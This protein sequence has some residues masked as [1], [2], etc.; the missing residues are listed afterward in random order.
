MFLNYINGDENNNTVYGG[1]DPDVI[2]GL[3]GDDLLD[4]AA[5]DDR[6]Y[7]G[8]GNDTLLGGAER[9]LLSG[10]AGNDDL[11]GGADGDYMIG[12]DGDDSLQ[13]G[14]G[15]DTLIG[16][17]GT[18]TLRGGD[19]DDTL[20]GGGNDD[21]LLGGPGKTTYVFARNDGRDI[22]VHDPSTF[23]ARQDVVKFDAG[24]GMSDLWI[25]RIERGVMDDLRILVHT[26]RPQ[27]IILQGFMSADADGA[28]SLD[29]QEIR[30]ADGAVVD[31][32]AIIARLL[33]PS[34]WADTLSGGMGADVIDAKA[35][36]D[37]VAGGAGDDTISGGRGNDQLRGGA[38]SDVYL[39]AVGDGRDTLADV[40]E[41]GSVHG[42]IIRF[43]L[44]VAPEDVRVVRSGT[45]LEITYGAGDVI[46]L[47]DGAAFKRIDYQLGGYHML[48][49]D[50][51]HAPVLQT[52]LADQRAG[53]GRVFTLEVPANTFHDRDPGTVLA[54]TLT[55]ADGA[56]LP[57]W[58][59]FDPASATLHG[60]VPDGLIGSVALLLTAS[61]QDGAQASDSLILTIGV[62]NNAP[63]VTAGSAG[64][65]TSEGRFFEVA[66]PSFADPDAGDTLALSMSMSAV[67]WALPVWMSFDG[68][69]TIRGVADH[70]TAGSYPLIAT[71]TDAGG[72]SVHSAFT[73]VIDDV[74]R[75]PVPSQTI[76]PVHAARN[77]PFNFAVPARAIV[78]PDGDRMTW[79][80]TGEGGAAL[81]PWLRFDA[82]S[83]TFSGVPS[84]SDAGQFTVLLSATDA[85]GASATNPFQIAVSPHLA[86]RFGGTD[87]ANVLSGGM[88]DDTLRGLDGNDRLS[89]LEGDDVLDGGLGN[90][91]LIGGAGN[92]YY[93]VEAADVVV[94]LANQGRDEIT[95]LV[96]MTM[97]AWV[98]VL[99]LAGTLHLAATGNEAE[100]LLVGNSG[101]NVL[102]GMGGNDILRGGAG[103]DLLTDS[104]GNN[105]FDGG[106]GND[107]LGG[108]AGAE[109]FIGGAG[110]DVIHPG[111]GRNTIAFNRGDGADELRTDG[112]ATENVISLG[113]GIPYASLSL[114]KLGND[115]ILDTGAGDQISLSQWYAS[116]ARQSVAYL[117]VIINE[118]IEWQAGS[119]N[120]AT[121]GPV[122][123]FDFKALGALF[124]QARADDPALLSWS[125]GQ[126]LAA[127]HLQGQSEAA[128][129]GSLAYQYGVKGT[130]A[131]VGQVAA[132]TIIG[133]SDFGDP[134]QAFLAPLALA[135][136]SGVLI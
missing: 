36:D 53:H 54:L 9:D 130:L 98:E 22:V 43:N 92:D 68:K 21:L 94:E 47:A 26:A 89:G 35:G 113:R 24:I 117:Q 123:L 37:I 136:A 18:D 76:A 63:T 32:E 108:G 125:M 81:P 78:H 129:G 114:R 77:T 10:D 44:S 56:A 124:D 71:A 79:S 62:P 61:D 25:E 12:G 128:A 107:T 28:V 72:L 23:G 127:T 133:S 29:L 50:M 74:H 59:S 87:A 110:N 40:A 85:A 20:D 106:I 109:M 118:R 1:A 99:R 66:V 46:V 91:T 57:D 112:G 11:D 2:S 31:N 55:Q 103:L 42:N 52:P 119:V 82:L 93:T 19:G 3:G 38:G 45:Q 4:G 49:V 14:A 80:A 116:P 27:E 115:L 73:L 69:G 83:R 96:S 41:A 65:T 33:R 30:F 51:N 111:A 120:P 8:A 131:N 97:P 70:F 90:D 134:N 105:L 132:L 67:G 95:S 13:G 88:A 135:D 84:L 100:N 17:F 101:N 75:A 5:N 126:A 122:H 104:Q 15:Q 39:F 48:D 64:L 60:M 34:E 58:L 121:V 6:L 7:G 102:R 86:M 16:G